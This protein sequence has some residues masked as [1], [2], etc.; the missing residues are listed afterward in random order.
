MLCPRRVG[1]PRIAMTLYYRN[2]LTTMFVF[3]VSGNIA[4]VPRPPLG[5]WWHKRGAED[6]TLLII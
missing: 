5:D 2:R 6:F 4:I 3:F 1:V